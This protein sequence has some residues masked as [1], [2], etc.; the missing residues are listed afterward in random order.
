MVIIWNVHSNLRDTFD[1]R[2]FWTTAENNSIQFTKHKYS[3]SELLGRYATVILKVK[4]RF[5]EAL[6]SYVHRTQPWSELCKTLLFALKLI[7]LDL[8]LV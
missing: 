3:M 5:Y 7:Y 6:I 4:P 2:W 8:L 1:K